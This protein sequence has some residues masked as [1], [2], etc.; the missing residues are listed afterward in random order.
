VC[1]CVCVCVCGEMAEFSRAELG[2]EEQTFTTLW[3]QHDTQAPVSDL[4]R[5]VT[6]SL[7]PLTP[8]YPDKTEVLTQ[9][10]QQV[11]SG[12]WSLLRA[13]GCGLLLPQPCKRSTRG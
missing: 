3:R 6:S 2:V 13:H 1:V 8:R 11:Q 7:H 4:G 12:Q 10:P 5:T 9:H